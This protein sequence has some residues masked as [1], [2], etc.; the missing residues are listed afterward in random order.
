MPIISHDRK[1][2]YNLEALILQNDG[3]PLHGEI[4][5]YR[6]IYKDC[7]A[8]QYTWHF[9]HDLRLNIPINKQAEIQ[10]DFF[11]VCEKGAIVVEVKGGKVGMIEG[12][13][14]YEVNHQRLFMNRSPFVQ[15]RDYMQA[16]IDSRII[17]RT[18][19]YIDTVC[20]FPHSTL[21]HT[22][23]N[24]IADL[25]YKLWSRS[26]Q[27]D[28]D[29][30][31]ADF[32]IDV[33]NADRERCS[34][35]FYDL[36]PDEVEIAISSLLNTFEDRAR[37]PYSEH[38]I[39]S[40]LAR[41]QIDNLSVFNSLQKND[42]LFIEGGPGTGKTTIAKAYIDKYHTLRGLYLCWNKLLESSF[43]YYL[44]QQ[45][46]VN[47]EVHQFASFVHKIENKL[48]MHLTSIEDISSGKAMTHVKN[49]TSMLR[50]LPDFHP[51]DYIIVDE[52]QDTLD[53][54]V[55]HIINGLSAVTADGIATGRYLVFYDIEQ[56][57][58]YTS[59]LSEQMV[60][61]LYPAGAHFLLDVNRRVPTNKEI[62]S[63]ANSLLSDSPVSDVITNI[64]DSNYDS[65]KVFHFE[66]AKSLIRHINTIK[67]EVKVSGAQWDDF[68]VLADSSTKHQQSGGGESLYDRIAT[69][70]GIKDLTPHNICVDTGELP[71]T[72][73][74][75]YKGLECKHV[76]LVINYRA[77][78]DKLELYVGMTRAI[79][80]L[81]ILI[82]E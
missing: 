5:M 24:P 39:Q 68:V 13:Y 35:P 66:G 37:N 29:I 82:L 69:I 73:I 8:S 33:L 45:G 18:Q 9:W 80:D 58:H 42:R 4:D 43:R 81:Q 51:Y 61:D 70:D 65:I 21:E 28:A 59:D 17:N 57:Y 52:A 79:V 7:N 44:G 62:V 1:D 34:K 10:I 36:Y 71:F 19:I 16:L 11:L 76:V 23:D 60:Q 14:Y 47:C 48:G 32:C 46:F 31:F 40:I 30:S 55:S 49:L 64:E 78:V 26:K 50:S 38:S 74:L 56:G 77:K 3:Q 67:K 12:E 20:A 6:R 63:F 15:A 25:G 53:K 22:T 2:L 27:E 41:L 75:T 54:G 72:S